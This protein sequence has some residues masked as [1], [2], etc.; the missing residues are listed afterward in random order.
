MNATDLLSVT[1]IR[2]RLTASL[3]GRHMYLLGEVDS[4]NDR[5]RSLAREGARQGT[6]LIAE[7]QTAGRGR[8]G[9]P[10]FSPSG[11]NFYASVL[12]RPRLRPR[13]L[14]IFSL[15]AA[16]ALS[17]AIKDVGA[18]PTIKWPNDVLVGGKKVGA[19]L[20]ECAVRD[21]EVAYVILGVGANLNVDASVLRAALGTGGRFAT[22]LAAVTGRPIDRN[23]FAASYLNHLDRWLSVHEME[24]SEGIL[25]AWRRREILGGRRV[26]VRAPGET[27]DGRVLGVDEHGN[28]LVNGARGRRH[29]LTSEEIR[30]LD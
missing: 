20:L 19:S 8:H 16:L 10:W 27:Y 24:G 15:L 26:E 21:D 1:E 18:D 22:S 23:A 29:V 9:Q 12:L 14:G 4:T 17:D 2:R 28:L 7:S 6:V 11:V 3:V 13:E 5:L 30:T 25:A